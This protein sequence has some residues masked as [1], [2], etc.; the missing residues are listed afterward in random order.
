[1]EVEFPKLDVFIDFQLKPQISNFA[2]GSHERRGTR[3]ESVGRAVAGE[4]GVGGR[5]QKRAAA[6]CKVG[7]ACHGRT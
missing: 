6:W 7:G 4:V 5:S 3:V 1:M 2:G